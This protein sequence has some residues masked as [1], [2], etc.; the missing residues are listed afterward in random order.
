MGYVTLPANE[1]YQPALERRLEQRGRREAVEH[2]GAVGAE[3]RGEGVVVGV[4]RVDHDRLAEL[5]RDLELGFE[6]AA[7]VVV[8]RVLAEVV[9]AGLADRDGAR[10]REQVA[11]LVEPVRVGLVGVVRVDAESGVD[12]VVLLG[13]RER[14]VAARD[15]RRDGDHAVDAD[16]AR[17]LE[18]LGCV[19][20]I[21]MRVSVD[22]A[23]PSSSSTTDASSF[24]KSGTGS[25]SFWPGGSSLGCQRPIHSA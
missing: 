19:V 2:D 4:A 1:T 8:R 18:D 25:R 6:E 5:G 10:V 16:G 3:Q 12:A 17:P 11:Q 24:L 13:K 20:G 23:R 14:L 7:L 21:E 9:E 22:H 15:A